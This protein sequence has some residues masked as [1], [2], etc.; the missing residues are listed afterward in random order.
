VWRR[1]APPHTIW[2]LCPN[3][4][5]SYNCKTDFGIFIAGNVKIVLDILCFSLILN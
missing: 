3:T 2:V 4:G 5:D 1:F